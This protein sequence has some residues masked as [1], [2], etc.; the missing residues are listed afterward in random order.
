MGVIKGQIGIM[1]NMETIGMTV[2]M[3]GYTG[4][5]LG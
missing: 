2:I 3:G 5:I 1:E 4:A